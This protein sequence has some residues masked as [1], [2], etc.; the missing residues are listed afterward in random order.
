MQGR[1]Q[2]V[3]EEVLYDTTRRWSYRTL[4]RVN[5]HQVVVSTPTTGRVVPSSRPSPISTSTT[6]ATAGSATRR[7]R[8]VLFQEVQPGLQPAHPAHPVPGRSSRRAA[9][10][11]SRSRGPGPAPVRPTPTR[12][13]ASGE[14]SRNGLVTRRAARGGIGA[15]A[16]AGT[17]LLGRSGLGLQLR[18]DGTD[19]WTF[20]ADR[21]E[22][23]VEATLAGAGWQ[24]EETGPLRVRARLDGRLGNS[25]VRLTVSL[26]RGEPAVRVELEVNFDER[27]TLLQ[28]PVALAG[29]GARWTDGI[30]DG[31]VD[32]SSGA[33]PSG[34][35]SAGRGSGS[36]AL[37]LG[38]RDHDCYSHSV[39][40]DDLAADA[41]PQSAHGLGRR[42]PAD[43]CRPRPAHRPG[44]PPFRLHAPLRRPRCRSRPCRG[45]APAAPQPLVVFDR[46]E[47][48][49]RPA[50]GP[51]PPRGLWGPAMLRNVAEGRVADP[52]TDEPGGLFKR[53]G[54]QDYAG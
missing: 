25:R 6:G 31:H 47:G 3:G 11:S 28:M 21:W 24:V 16:F 40:G 5:E 15:I 17:E 10:A 37:D 46:Y 48:M 1:A 52:G 36:A 33:R 34:R 39:D 44:R 50:W 12:L 45:A 43:L 4:P 51:V 9:A 35:S 53:P 27:Y 8:P 18:K 54:H 42:R 41:A 30:A 20:H 23:P 2:I 14:R 26:C 29:A 13:S 38:V 22:E 32:R 7:E 19:T 49:N